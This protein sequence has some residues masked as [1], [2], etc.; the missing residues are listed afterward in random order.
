MRALWFLGL[1]A[2]SA[3]VTSSDAQVED[4]SSGTTYVNIFDFPSTD[5]GAWSDLVGKLNGEFANV[6]GDTFCEGDFA[7]LTPLTF[8]CSVSS[9]VGQVHDCAWTFAGSYAFAD[10]KTSVIAID[11]PTFVCHVAPKTT[12]TKLIALL[13]GSADAIHETLPGTTGSIY[14]SLVDCFQHPIGGTP[15]TPNTTAGTYV[16]SDAYYTS[17][18][19]I[20][21]WSTV[22]SALLAGFNNICGDTFCGSDYGDLQALQLACS[23]TKSSGNVKSCVWIFGGSVTNVS[24][25]GADVPTT[26]TF[27]CPIPMHGT[28]A[29]LV[30]ALTAPGVDAIQTPL[31]GVTTSAYDSLGGC[32]P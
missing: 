28:M 8:S 23:V 31:P 7:N 19:G 1:T 21:K 9:K 13:S 18:A 11:A 15:F 24:K 5:Q 27:S 14:D 4:E 12:S 2:I 30:S 22:K 29:Q 17:A 32:L 6:C 10:P 16:D 25:T 3:C 20:A 26:K